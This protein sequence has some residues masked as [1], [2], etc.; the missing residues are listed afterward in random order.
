MARWQ[1][2]RAFGIEIDFDSKIAAHPPA[3]IK[4]KLAAPIGNER[5]R[6]DPIPADRKVPSTV[7]IGN[8]VWIP[9]AAHVFFIRD[10]NHVMTEVVE[11]IPPKPF[12]GARL[13][14]RPEPIR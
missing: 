7:W 14:V 13:F 9:A 3:E 4:L 8:P 11:W 6:E 5:Q 10:A 2:M 12:P 1:R